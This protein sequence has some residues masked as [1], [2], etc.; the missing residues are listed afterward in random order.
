MIEIEKHKYVGDIAF[1]MI[2]MGTK[3]MMLT[4]S[5]K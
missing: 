3:N 2:E 5:L 1:I 4:L